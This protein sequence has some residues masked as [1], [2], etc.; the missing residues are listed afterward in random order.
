MRTRVALVIAVLLAGCM[1]GPDYT[2]PK[3]DAAT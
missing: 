3:I 2:R 1:M